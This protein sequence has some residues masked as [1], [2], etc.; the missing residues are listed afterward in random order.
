MYFQS[1]IKMVLSLIMLDLSAACELWSVTQGLSFGDS[2]DS[3][4]LD[5]KLDIIQRFGLLY[6]SYVD[7]TQL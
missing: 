3:E 5:T 7:N 4:L 2:Q 1:K 6:L